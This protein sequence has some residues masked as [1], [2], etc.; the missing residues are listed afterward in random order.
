[1][2]TILLASIALA[3]PLSQEADFSAT[4][5]SS[6]PAIDGR[7]DDAAWGDAG[8]Q[9]I[10][11]SQFNPSYGEP[12]TDPTDVM[13][14]YD[15]SNIYFG[16]RM[17]QNGQIMRDGLTFRD[18]Y[19][20]GEWIAILLDSHG[21]HQQCNSFEVSLANSQMDSRILR[22]NG[23]WDYTWDAVWESAT[24]RDENG[25]TAEM[26]IP[27][28][29]L[30]YSGDTLQT[31]NVNFQRIISRGGQNGWCFLSPTRNQCDIETFGKLGGLHGLS[32]SLNAEFRPYGAASVLN[33]QPRDEWEESAD[34]GADLKLGLGSDLVADL[35]VNPDFGQ[36]EADA[37]EMNLS[38][39]ESMLAEKRPFFMESS[40]LFDMPFNMFYSR[41]IGSVAP[42]GEVIPILAGAKVSGHLSENF[43]I[44]VLD[45][46]T[47]RVWDGSTLA[48]PAANY[49]IFSGRYRLGADSFIGLHGVSREAPA[50]DDMDSEYNRAT[51]AE[52]AVALPA[53]HV[54]GG[55][56]AGS[57][58]SF[59]DPSGAW[60]VYGGHVR[61]TTTY[62]LESLYK[63]RDFDVNGTGYTAET[64]V[65]HNDGS[66]YHTWVPAAAVSRF[67]LGGHGWY[68]RQREGEVTGQGG[69][70]EAITQFSSGAYTNMNVQIDGAS[71]D[72]YEGPEGRGYPQRASYWVD[73]GTNRFADYTAWAGLGGGDFWS[74]GGFGNYRVALGAR[75]ISSLRTSLE[76][77]LFRTWD[78]DKYNWENGAFEKRATDWRSLTLRTR[79]LFTPQL[80]LRLFSQLSRFTSDYSGSSEAVTTQ[81][82]T[83][84]LMGW[85]YRPGSML[86]VLVENSAD[87]GDDGELGTPSVGAYA[88]L[89]W[90]LPF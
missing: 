67:A 9:T 21:D 48:V 56:L 16:L 84:L 90:F 29:C 65:F 22:N 82:R 36:V 31:W 15:D 88:K 64:G 46:V 80:S 2:L 12:Q 70:I 40:H 86:Y 72:P 57:W 8:L 4:P 77:Q 89:T 85:E 71:Y 10:T 11:F 49:G 27:L 78:A 68:N 37:E 63:G 61:G 25:W 23:G 73:A 43:S 81:L 30:R 51:A 13:I 35:T 53:G 17:H 24:T 6:A 18:E 39:F 42:N 83:N 32:R 69:R 45:A 52:L 26:R 47:G 87:S 1:M 14:V 66:F 20:T 58:N 5:T 28:S 60:S 33:S 44:G 3:S 41:R 74:G 79:Y 55:S 38:H 7:L 62:H 75:P 54:L 59:S 76:G 50:Q 34:V 19:V